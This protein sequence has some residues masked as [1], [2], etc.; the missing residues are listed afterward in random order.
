MLKVNIYTDGACSGNQSKTNIGGWGAVLE[1][2]DF[3][4]EMS[5]HEQNTTNNRMEM[6]ALIEALKALKKDN[7]EIRVFSDSSYLANC[8]RDKWYVK[9]KQNGWKNSKGDPVENQDLWVELLS[10]VEKHSVEFFR[11]KGH[12]NLN[13]D[14]SKLQTV[15]K[16][17][18]EWNGSEFDY[19]DFLYITK[20]NN[21][22]DSL[23]TGAYSA[24]SKISENL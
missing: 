18:I 7:L 22:A 1:Y 5:G 19:D 23:A 10:L 8:F 3:Q 11:V 15:F 21:I 6:K 17:F 9:W 24:N 13:S 12:V 2:G 20:M 16:K 14:D 4:K